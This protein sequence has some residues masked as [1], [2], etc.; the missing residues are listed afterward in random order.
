MCKKSKTRC[1]RGE[2]LCAACYSTCIASWVRPTRFWEVAACIHAPG[3][4]LSASSYRIRYAEGRGDHDGS[5]DGCKYV[6]GESCN[7]CR[8]GKKYLSS[9]L[10]GVRGERK[11]SLPHPSHVRR[12]ESRAM[13]S[14]FSGQSC[15]TLTV[16]LFLI[17]LFVLHASLRTL[18][19]YSPLSIRLVVQPTE[20][21]FAL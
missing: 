8:T 13:R 18:A 4:T 12:I 7:Y 9:L 21:C 14:S 10:H 19:V 2:P 3:K 11:A 1:Y 17:C 20:R 16:W 5:R 6:P 15:I